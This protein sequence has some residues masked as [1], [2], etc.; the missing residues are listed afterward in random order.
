MVKRKQMATDFR[1]DAETIIIRDHDG[2]LVTHTGGP[3]RGLRFD[4]SEYDL[5]SYAAEGFL[6]RIDAE[7]D[8]REC[9]RR[10]K[11]AM[12][13]S[14]RPCKFSADEVIR[15]AMQPSPVHAKIAPSVKETYGYVA[16]ISD[17]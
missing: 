6:F 2:A 13:R 9:L 4:G 10:H 1:R 15:A 8:M 3:Y 17:H 7:E 14:R 11:F 16:H 5:L 12:W